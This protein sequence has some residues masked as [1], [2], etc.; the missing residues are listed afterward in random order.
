MEDGRFEDGRWKMKMKTVED[1]RWKI[2]D[3]HFLKIEF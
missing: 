1:G 2:E 3:E